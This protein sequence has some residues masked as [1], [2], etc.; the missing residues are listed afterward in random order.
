MGAVGGFEERVVDG[1]CFGGGDVLGVGVL[2]VVGG[3]GL[4]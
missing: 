3:S 1:F 2:E 4:E